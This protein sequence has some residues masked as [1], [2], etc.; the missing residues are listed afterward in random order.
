MKNLKKCGLISFFL[1]SFFISSLVKADDP[2]PPNYDPIANGYD[3]LSKYMTLNPE[4]VDYYGF[5]YS[6]NYLYNFYEEYV[7]LCL[8]Y[9]RSGMKQHEYLR[10]VVDM[11]LYQIPP[12]MP[13][14]SSHPYGDNLHNLRVFA[15]PRG[16]IQVI[17]YWDYRDLNYHYLP[18][19]YLFG[20]L[21]SNKQ[22]VNILF[23]F[24]LV[25]ISI[26]WLVLFYF[27]FQ[28]GLRSS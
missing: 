4:P 1:F 19:N 23:D 28:M 16:C 22:S 9:T 7:D 3:W 13:I 8:G 24:F 26:A 12:Q 11:F 17:S 5:N 25:F 27:G 21:V 14:P 20:E 10:Y 2:P 15:D 6:P 18:L